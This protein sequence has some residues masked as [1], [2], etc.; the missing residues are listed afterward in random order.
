MKKILLGVGAA[1]CVVAGILAI[2]KLVIPFIG[3]VFSWL[4]GLF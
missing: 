1:I 4:R 2:W 3:V